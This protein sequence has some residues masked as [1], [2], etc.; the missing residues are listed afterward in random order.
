MRFVGNLPNPQDLNYEWIISTDAGQIADTPMFQTL[1]PSPLIPV[2]VTVTVKSSNG[3]GGFG[4]ITFTLR[5][6][7]EAAW[8]EL[9]CHLG[10]LAKKS[11]GMA[12]GR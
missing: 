8:M 1:L 10:E 7:A 5:S 11:S 9:I 2:T 12:K 4:T 6:T 3:C